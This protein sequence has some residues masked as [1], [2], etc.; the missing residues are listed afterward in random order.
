M[1]RLTDASV[2]GAKAGSSTRDIYDEAES[3]LCLRVQPTGRKSWALRIRIAGKQRRFNIGAYPATSLAEA[4]EYASAMKKAAARGYDP[5]NVLRPAPSGNPTVDDAIKV[6]METKKENRS[7]AME[8]RRFEL[9]VKPVLGTKTVDEVSR[10][11][12][13]NLLHVMV[14]RHG[15]R[16]EPNRVFTS[17]RGFWTWVVYQRGYRPDDPMAGMKRPVRVEPSQ[18]RQKAGT[19]PLLDLRGLA[20]LW[21]LAP[22]L[23]SSVLPDLVRCML[24]VP[25]RREEWTALTWSEVRLVVEDGW[26]GRALKVPAERMKGGRPAVVPLPNQIVK[27]LDARRKITGASDYVFSVPGRNAPFA[28]WR[29]AA[30]LLRDRLHSSIEWVP[31]DLR[32]S[33]ATALA[34]DI[35]A[36]E[37]II[38]RILQHS[39][40]TLLGV[41]AIYQKSPRLNEQ[42]EAL[43]SWCDLLERVAEDG[44]E[45]VAR[46][47]TGIG[48]E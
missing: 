45:E 22:S 13:D 23:P 7:Q 20:A 40:D 33:V 21:K 19:V 26:K 5:A 2:R 42:A 18:A 11:D 24:A 34:R 29:R 47:K 8:R 36:D 9:H 1:A 39:N 27:I 44:A 17:L 37:G 46:L 30:D 10:A 16:A 12:I 6:Y 4:R 14:H 32:R 25:L 41:T 3:S 31:H 15:L 38:K 35:R 43:Q 28:G 48:V